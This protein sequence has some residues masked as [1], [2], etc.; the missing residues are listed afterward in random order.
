LFP[1]PAEPAP[2]L[3]WASPLTVQRQTVFILEIHLRRSSRTPWPEFN[4]CARTLRRRRLTHRSA[5]T[6]RP[7]GDD[8]HSAPSR[9][10]PT[11]A[12]KRAESRS[13]STQGLGNTVSPSR[14]P[15]PSAAPAPHWF[16]SS[17]TLPLPPIHTVSVKN[18]S[19]SWWPPMATCCPTMTWV[20]WRWSCT[21]GG[22]CSR[23]GG[24]ILH[25]RAA[26]SS[27][28][29][30]ARADALMR[31]CWGFMLLMEI[32]GGSVWIEDF[33][34]FL[35]Y[36]DLV[37]RDWI[38][39]WNWNTNKQIQ[40]IAAEDKHVISRPATF[41]L[42]HADGTT[43]FLGKALK[44][45]KVYGKSFFHILIIQYMFVEIMVVVFSRDVWWCV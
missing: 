32:L 7:R 26:E 4:P 44:F 43:T 31:P 1:P 5:P 30:T 34:V 42:V 10:Y 37:G 2:V 15:L 12:P 39:S 23:S 25:L 41:A 20:V 18:S 29:C 38:L 27:R 9:R 21:S 24:G 40:S 33:C 28:T 19:A 14:N 16:V 11:P 13:A 6:P 17:P 36:C 22:S 35:Y 8:R 45:I 3:W